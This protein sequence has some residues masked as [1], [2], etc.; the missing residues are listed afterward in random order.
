[1]NQ[2]AFQEMTVFATP[3]LRDAPSSEY[4]VNEQTPDL[5]PIDPLI[6]TGGRESGGRGL[7]AVLDRINRSESRFAIEV[8]CECFEILESGQVDASLCIRGTVTDISSGGI[9]IQLDS[10]PP[11]RL[12]W[13]LV[14]VDRGGQHYMPVQIEKI[15][16]S[17]DGCVR[18]HTSFG[19][20][21][22]H[23]FQQELWV[24]KFDVNRSQY[25]LPFNPAIWLS[26][27][28]IGAVTRQSLDY[29]AS[30]NDCGGMVTTRFG[31]PHCLSAHV[32]QTR[33]IHHY[34]CA[35]VDIAERFETGTEIC[36]PKCRGRR[37]IIGADYEYLEGPS[38]CEDCGHGAM[39]LPPLAHCMSCGRRSLLTETK[40][41]E[42]IGYHV[43]RFSYLDLVSHA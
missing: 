1:M 2:T 25:C 9:G 35:H 23:L 29:V 24:P 27:E 41:Q 34:A 30:C 32:E 37:L 3:V 11:P 28:M 8:P 22:W 12:R 6:R 20:S 15:E 40:T 33:M 42:I 38:R 21:L 36:C 17:P 39:Q 13:L 18:L 31:C 5:L 4:A 43:H 26:L 19:G 10:L 14:G 16:E 7:T